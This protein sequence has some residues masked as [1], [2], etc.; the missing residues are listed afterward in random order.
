MQL[1][2]YNLR[3]FIL[4]SHQIEFLMHRQFLLFLIF[5]S[6][7]SHAQEAEGYQ[8]KD[9]L[10]ISPGEFEQQLDS[11][12]KP[13]DSLFDNKVYKTSTSDSISFI[14]DSIP[15]V[16]KIKISAQDS[17]MFLTFQLPKPR[18]LKNIVLDTVTLKNDTLPEMKSELS[19]FIE[20]FSL[21]HNSK[22]LMGKMIISLLDTFSLERTNY[23]K[24]LVRKREIAQMPIKEMNEITIEDYKIFYSDGRETFLDTTLN[25]NKDYRFNYLRKDY[26]ELLPF[27]NTAETY[28]KM[29]YDF[30][31]QKLTP[32][33][34]ARA[35]H[36]GYQEEEEIPYFEVPS[37][38]TELFFKTVFEQGQMVDVLITVNP[39]PRFNF[40]LAHKAY[41]SLGNY[42][43]TRSGGTHVTFASQYT[44]RNY[45]Y[46]QR[47]HYVAQNLQ[48]Q[49]NGGLN[50][51]S[52]YHFE[53]AISELD[54][55]GFLDRS[56]L[57]NNINADNS[58]TGRRYYLDQTYVLVLSGTEKQKNYEKRKV[59]TIGHKLN[60][61]IKK[62]K[63]LNS[64]RTSFFG[65]VSGTTNFEDQ[66]NLD[67]LENEFYTVYNDK[68]FGE[69]KAGLKFINW[70]YFMVFP[71]PKDDEEVPVIDPVPRAIKANQFALSSYWK[72][73]FLDYNF[74]ATAYFSLIKEFSTQQITGEI[75][76]D[77]KNFWS[78]RA[79][80]SLRS[81]AP[82]FNFFLHR[83]NFVSYDWN[84]PE[85]KNQLINSLNLEFGHP[86][87]GKI[88][89]NYEVLNNHAYFK[90]ILPEKNEI[91]EELIV[92]P[93]QFEGTINYL[94]IRLVQNLDFWK[95]SL[96]NTIQY[97]NVDQTSEEGGF[98]VVNV[99][100][101][102]GRSS[103]TFSSQL[104]NKALFLQTGV[105]AQYFT[106]YY[107]DRYSAPIGEFVAQNHTLIGEF[108]RIDFFV[109]AKVQQTRIF[110]K[111]EHVNSDRTGYNFYSAPFTPYR[112]SIIRFGIV[113]N[114]FQ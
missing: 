17:L 7:I 49:I 76:K 11:M 88:N 6:L 37:P 57:T 78:A 30:Q 61:E 84:Q 1:N 13:N 60:Y 22:L 111:Y 73:T 16:E 42:I 45:R 100:E 29:G 21:D 79:K 99:P 110:F 54:Y 14:A 87:W 59:L 74:K 33:I 15:E 113:W 66:T 83:S 23:E 35:K 5:F 32:Q 34:G 81:Q 90:N 65:V 56:R 101:W 107:A 27:P 63:Y 53:K 94:K 3:T 92:A 72:K 67:V 25:I 44:S 52:V 36:F 48:N 82:N 106:N 98:Q 62:F 50:S 26:F 4:T 97:Q 24:R 46:R 18:V 10:K 102:I 114:F 70:D 69:I 80:L 8:V 89:A 19:G 43:N 39:S 47:S 41:R 109:N 28:N 64:E 77:F 58:L 31:D 38:V 95:F 85:Y 96:I 20:S 71:E 108:P 112:D 51:Q 103:L 9:T 55:D 93:T 86:K 91:A 2:K 104:F 12:T 105:T 68:I 40:T 75:S